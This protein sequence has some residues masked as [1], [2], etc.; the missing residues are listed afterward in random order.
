MKHTIRI[1]IRSIKPDTYPS[2][3]STIKWSSSGRLRKTCWGYVNS[4]V[5]KMPSTKVMFDC[6]S[7]PLICESFFLKDVKYQHEKW[8]CVC[9][10]HRSWSVNFISG[11]FIEITECTTYIYKG[12]SW[13]CFYDRTCNLESSIFPTIMLSLLGQSWFLFGWWL[14]V[15]WSVWFFCLHFSRLCLYF[16]CNQ[17]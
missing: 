15:T 2:H 10:W 17:Q 3:V 9:K 16:L 6:L 11:T 13:K 4:W 5:E 12:Y 7:I 14:H 1:Y 8:I